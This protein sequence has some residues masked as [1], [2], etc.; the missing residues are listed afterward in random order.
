MQENFR[1]VPE[2]ASTHAQQVDALFWFITAVCAFFTMLI[3]FLV[4]YFT[5]RY[6]YRSEA[7]RSG[8]I[9]SHV[10]LEIAW[11]VIPLA[12]A[13]VMFF[14]GA[15]LYFDIHQP[16]RRALEI[17]VLA[18]QWMWKLQQPGG[19]SEINELHVPLGQPVKL[20]MISEDVIHSFFVPAFRVKMDVLPGRY[21]YAWFT[22]S[23]VGQ[24]HLF[25]AEY[26]GTAH[27]DMIGRVVVMEPAAYANWLRG[28]TG[29]APEVVGA[30]LFEQFRCHTCH[31]HLRTAR[32]PP[33]AGVYG[34]QVA[35]RDG[36]VVVADDEYLRESILNPQAQIVAGYQPVMPTFAGQ[37][38]EEGILQLI[39]YLKTL[40]PQD[41]PQPT[42][43]AQP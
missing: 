27:A 41:T 40:G 5:A 12:L 6:R 36:R 28:D 8:W 1:L 42:S 4:L 13:L 7:D 33:L 11:S 43:E 20:K 14:W 16:P 39:A 22:P 3:C 25:C 29:E 37:I 23:K 9:A 2:Q 10:P 19:K 24:Y 18:K 15:I 35:L 34:R 32:C 17:N 30:R 21:T 38:S 26:C 31:T